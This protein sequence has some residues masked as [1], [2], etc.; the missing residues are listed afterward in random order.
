MAADR[1]F[2]YYYYYSRYG[3]CTDVEYSNVVLCGAFVDINN[4]PMDG[5][6][7]INSS[8]SLLRTSITNKLSKPCLF[9]M[10][11]I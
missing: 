6:A 7:T 3:F 4:Y 5:L 8:M 9:G 10:D 2:Y 11:S 1:H